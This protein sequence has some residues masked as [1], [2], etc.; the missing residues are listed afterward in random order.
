MIGRLA[1][2]IYTIQVARSL[3]V[4]TAVAAKPVARNIQKIVQQFQEQRTEYAFQQHWPVYTADADRDNYDTYPATR[5]FM[6]VRRTGR[7][8]TLLAA[9]RLTKILRLETSLSFSMWHHAVQ[10]RAFLSQL[11]KSKEYLALRAAAAKGQAWDLTRLVTRAA[12]L[13]KRRWYHKVSNTIAL[14]TLFRAAADSTGADA[15]WFFTCSG[16]LKRF[17]DRSAIA[18]RQLAHGKIS[19]SDDEESYLCVSNL[20]EALAAMSQKKPLLSKF[21]AFITRKANV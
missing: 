1:Q 4:R 2:L 12:L 20:S 11:R 16:Q 3:R 10:R 17:L 8:E 7:R 6:I 19:A 5:Y 13:P 15:V 21:L 18:Y 9:M 14:L